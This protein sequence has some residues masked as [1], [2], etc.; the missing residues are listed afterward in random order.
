[1]A[2]QRAAVSVHALSVSGNSVREHFHSFSVNGNSVRG[3]VMAR[4]LLAVTPSEN[5]H[6]LSV[7]G[8]SVRGHC[9]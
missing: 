3:R 4:S 2:R 1:M 7:N 6:S 8:N 5:L 9:N